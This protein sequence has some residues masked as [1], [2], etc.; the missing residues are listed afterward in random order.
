MIAKLG[1]PGGHPPTWA[2]ENRTGLWGSMAASSP[3]SVPWRDA[4]L[5]CKFD[6]PRSH[7]IA[8]R[9]G[10]PDHENLSIL[11]ALDQEDE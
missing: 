2:T 8:G 9:E 10:F 6:S 3:R 4:W 7:R 1:N 5:R 11:R